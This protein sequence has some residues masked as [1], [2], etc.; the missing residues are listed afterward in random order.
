M[1][2][3]LLNSFIPP[4]TETTPATGSIGE[5]VQG[6]I[7]TLS[8]EDD[9]E[10]LAAVSQLSSILSLAPEDSFSSISIENLISALVI[11]L[12]KSFPDISLYTLMSI[13]CIFDSVANSVNAFAAC[14]GIPPLC[15][16]LVNFEYIDMAEHAIKTLERLAFDH[17]S[18][19]LNEG[20]FTAMINMM[21]FFEKNTQV[22]II[23]FAVTIA[24]NVS[25][26][27]LLVNHIIPVLPVIANTLQFRGSESLEMNRLGLKFFSVLGESILRI[28]SNDLEKLK[29]HLESIAEFGMI[30]NIIELVSAS[31]EFKLPCFK[32]I[33]RLSEHSAE[34]VFLFHQIGGISI[35]N[36]VLSSEDPQAELPLYYLEAINLVDSLLP[37]SNTDTKLLQCYTENAH[38]LS[39][40]REIIFPRILQIYE[41]SV[42]KSV[43]QILLNII[44]KIIQFSNEN[45]SLQ[46][47]SPAQ[48][49]CFT[50]EVMNSKS[51]E[52]IRTM[53]TIILLL[54]E[55]IPEEVAYSFLREG[56]SEKVQ[57]LKN[58][59]VVKELVEPFQ[60]LYE[61]IANPLNDLKKFVIK[62]GISVDSYM[63]N[64]VIKYNKQRLEIGQGTEAEV[65]DKESALSK[66]YELAH[67]DICKTIEEIIKKVDEYYKPE[68]LSIGSE[69]RTLVKDLESENSNGL[70]KL[71]DLLN[72]D[73]GLT[74]HEI[75]SSGLI[76]TLYNYLT[77]NFKSNIKTCTSRIQDFL[78]IF[79]KPS[80]N[81]QTFLDILTSHLVDLL[82]YVQH[83][84]IMLYETSGSSNSIAAL[85]SLSVRLRLTFLY[86]PPDDSTSP[87]L[88][89]QHQFFS[90][91]NSFSLNTESYH[92]FD[93]FYQAFLKITCQEHLD[94]FISAFERNNTESRGINQ[95]QLQMV[96]QQLRLQQLFL[97]HSDILSA[98][99]EKGIRSEGADELLQAMRARKDSSQ[100]YGGNEDIEDEPHIQTTYLD[101]RKESAVDLRNVKVKMFIGENEVQR[102]S[103]I[104][105]INS[106]NNSEEGLLIKFYFIL[107]NDKDEPLPSVL[108]NNLCEELIKNSLNTP[109]PNTEKVFTPICLLKLISLLNANLN[110]FLS[111]N[112][113]L[114]NSVNQ[115]CKPSS[116]ST[117][118]SYKLSALLGKQT[119]DM[120]AMVGGMAPDWIKAL[121]LHS[122]HLFNFSQRF[123]F[124]RSLAFGGGRSLY[125]YSQTK[126]NFSVRMLRQKA[127]VPRQGILEAGKKILSDPGLLRFGVLEFDFEGEEGTGTG[128]TL[129]FYTMI[130]E[131][132][133]KLDIWR[134]SGEKNGLFPGPLNGQDINK[135]TS[136][137]TFIGRLVAKALFDDRLL[138][139][140][141]NKV[142]WKLVLNKPLSLLDLESVDG[143]IGRY[144][145]ELN[146]IAKQKTQIIEEYQDI[147]IREKHIRR[148]DLKGVR[149]EDMHLTFTLPGYEH[150]ELKPNGKNVF[151]NI[152][153]IE[154]YIVRATEKTLLQ[155]CQA[156]AFRKGFEKL[157]PI[158]T[159]CAFELEELESVVCGKGCE[160]W[161]LVVLEAVVVPTHGYT[162]SSAVFKNLLKLMA[163]FTGEERKMF[164]QFVTG[165]P[166]LPIGGFKALTPPLTV[167]RRA[168]SNP[169]ISPDKYLPSV[170]TC[171]NYLKLPEYSS[172]QVLEK[173]IRYAFTEAKEAFHLS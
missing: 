164:L 22:K 45:F 148:I 64:E 14:G 25:S 47:I 124:F 88:A 1:A 11:C 75:T 77:Q 112:S 97:D 8:S 79:A 93:I 41:Q 154:E 169:K 122:P 110:N 165:C 94:S 62:T 117:F 82:K 21:D 139:L 123:E 32:L 105:E 86:Q 172:Y 101:V 35:I 118:I 153:N 72:S 131:E 60:S 98:L 29:K 44:R 27:D 52:S 68:A 78:Q 56:V 54:Y 135:I 48:F 149:V 92:I 70:I 121:P 46:G 90:Q 136:I 158:E 143:D 130:S 36:S 39:S 23:S 26:E 73:Q 5:I 125:F 152:E 53:L 129:E 151:V 16:K 17:S 24:S 4:E 126:K 33:R 13:N 103:T 20:V 145:L 157:F 134:D 37:K 71:K 144:I 166:R 163:S 76:T 6:L 58:F 34:I 91:I 95:G 80:R 150:I 31:N 10:V 69:L 168:P 137:F 133:R 155:T 102:Y 106:K 99:E 104:F 162:R 84:T 85:K 140:P 120:L 161:E 107:E 38:L 116:S 12:N 128:P 65:L 160:S 30:Q 115:L 61:L 113:V 96:R 100:I 171:Q 18:S 51:L 87:E 114:F 141:F 83:F 63:L 127:M 81:S 89:L 66:L 43:R 15:A 57:E 156:K 147:D 74:L 42:N 9:M 111:P 28:S 67:I 109:L 173:Q 19:L 59:S 49:A 146:Q 7:Q 138:N 159:L 40:L 167:V 108:I 55:K 3:T 2:D 132:I 119:S 142:F 170:M 50:S